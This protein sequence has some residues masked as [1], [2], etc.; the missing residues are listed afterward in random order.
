[1]AEQSQAARVRAHSWHVTF[2]ADRREREEVLRVFGG[3]LRAVR[4]VAGFSQGELADRCF[5]RHDQVS[6]LER[7]LRSPDLIALLILGHSLDVSIDQL[8][9]DLPAPMRRAGTAQLLDLITRQPGAT[10][11]QIE[12]SMGLP[13]WYIHRLAVQLQ[14]TG[15]IV[16][17][18]GWRPVRKP[19][20]ASG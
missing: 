14:A 19:S 12:G 7:G 6:A 4:G 11:N 13:P 20:N 15:A 9:T 8:T 2:G 5:M 1:M 16:P 3:K 17:G 10:M 18:A